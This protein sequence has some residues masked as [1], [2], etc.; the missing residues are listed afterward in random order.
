MNDKQRV[1]TGIKIALV[2]VFVFEIIVGLIMYYQQN[3]NKKA[4]DR[5][6]NVE[7][8]QESESSASAANNSAFTLAVNALQEQARVAN[9][10]DR[11]DEWI[12]AIEEIG[13][14]I[15]QLLLS[16]DGSLL[17][18]DTFGSDG[19]SVT[20]QEYPLTNSK[21]R[22]IC[23]TL[24]A[25][26]SDHGTTQRHAFLEYTGEQTY[27][28]EIL[29]LENRE[30]LSEEEFQV[31]DIKGQGYV[32]WNRYNFGYTTF[33]SPARLKD[34]VISLFIPGDDEFEMIYNVDIPVKA[35][36]GWDLQLIQQDDT[37]KVVYGDEMIT[38]ECIFNSEERIFELAEVHMQGES[39]DYEMPG[40]L[41]GLSDTDGNLRTLFIRKEDDTLHADEYRGEIIISQDKELFSVKQYQRYEDFY[42]D[43]FDNNEAFLTGNIDVQKLIYG[44]FGMD[45]AG[46]FDGV[47]EAD[48]WSY[49]RIHDIPL[50]IGDTYIC[51]IQSTY[52][53]GG[54][55]YQA[56]ASDIYFE[57]LEQLSEGSPEPGV[58]L[59]PERS[60]LAD[61]VYG[62]R[63]DVLY[64]NLPLVQELR[65]Y[66]YVDIRQLA[67][68]RSVG[69]W[70]L[71]LPVMNDYMHPGNGSNSRSITSFAAYDN[72]V[73][74]DLNSEDSSS[75]M[76]SGG[77]GWDAW[78]AK[79]Y[80]RLPQTAVNVI[81]Y[82]NYIGIRQSAS[83]EEFDLTIP[84]NVDEYI[85]SIHFID[86][87]MQQ[88]MQ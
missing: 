62:S 20:L 82:E 68:K 5:I 27:F 34:Y 44:P 36:D 11:D 85:V 26:V 73:P 52:E 30:T 3:E 61:L 69:A 22:I 75:E 63:A 2:I 54:G 1:Y 16:E 53:S 76:D 88:L 70:M 40:L 28:S 19:F 86:E 87:D 64:K 74:A 67:L 51:Y 42:E 46:E 35:M 31:F 15:Q 84:V 12:N 45:P 83:G 32:F 24:G 10:M 80:F 17:T 6:S 66:P 43:E 77:F 65:L 72:N 47:T 23:Y 33:D 71:M 60:A 25:N 78:R 8:E 21:V 37:V 18:N 7:I 9:Q 39:V 48:T 81:Q 41:L 79:D 59:M 29:Y 49:N 56:S 58:P 57:K 50:Y 14:G 4:S 13:K 38:P 55:T